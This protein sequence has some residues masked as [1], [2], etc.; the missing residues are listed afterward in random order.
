ME[1]IAETIS[2]AGE[3]LW[4]QECLPVMG[5]GARTIVLRVVE[6]T[7]TNL[8]KW[9]LP[10]IQVGSANIAFRF[11]VEQ[12]EK[13]RA[14]GDLRHNMANLCT[15]VMTPIT[16]P[17]W[18]H[19]AQLRKSVFQTKRDWVFLKSDHADAYKQLPLGPEYANLTAVCLRNPDTGEWCAFIPKVLLFGAVS[20]VIHYNCFI[21]LLAV[22][23]NRILGIPILN[24]FD[25]FG[26]LSPEPLG[27][28]A[29]SRWMI[30]T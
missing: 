16:L 12:Q 28:K 18:D 24:Y 4:L 26:S 20:S 10:G 21:R 2:G 15:S 9:R 17:T 5:G 27:A 29:L 19:I 14:C 30:S 23:M 8:S 6:R 25:D 11:G 7:F 22:L 1:I 3:C 13:L